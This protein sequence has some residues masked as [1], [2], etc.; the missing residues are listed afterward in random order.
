MTTNSMTE[1]KRDWPSILDRHVKEVAANH[2]E[3]SPRRIQKRFHSMDVTLWEGFV[4]VDDI[5]GYVENIR[6]KFYLKRWQARRGHAGTPTSDEIYE[7]M[8]EA[9][10]EEDKESQRPFHVARIAKDIAYKRNT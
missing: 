5:E 7:I 4:Y 8:L 9:D 3:Y 2:P 6:L 1:T 10:T